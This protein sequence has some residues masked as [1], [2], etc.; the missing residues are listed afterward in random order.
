MNTSQKSTKTRGPGYCVNT[1]VQALAPFASHS[2]RKAAR[3]AAKR[4]PIGKGPRG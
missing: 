2:A 1:L 3:R 4:P